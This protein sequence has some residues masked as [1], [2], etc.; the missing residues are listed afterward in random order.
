MQRFFASCVFFAILRPSD[1]NGANTFKNNTI[2]LDIAE[3]KRLGKEY[4]PVIWPGF[5]WHNLFPGSPSNQIKR[6][7]GKFYWTQAYNAISS[8]STMLY[9][10][11]FDEV[12][13]GTAIYKIASNRSMAPIEASWVS[14]DADGYNLPSDWYLRLASY[15]KKMLNKKIPL[16]KTM[17]IDP[18]H[19][20]TT[21]T[22]L[23]ERATQT[24]LEEKISITHGT[25]YITLQPNEKA[26]IT[27][28][29]ISGGNTK[30]WRYNNVQGTQPLPIPSENRIPNGIYLLKATMNTGR[31]ISRVVPVLQ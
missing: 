2:V 29:R 14:L 23:T 9:G 21:W 4:L 7:G 8:S 1:T 16:S 12:N 17:P 30:M 19:P 13:E 24:T 20:D 22:G 15:A 28:S 11:M 6:L 25:L 10:A 3:A 18:A 31:I 27:L 26:E 5:S